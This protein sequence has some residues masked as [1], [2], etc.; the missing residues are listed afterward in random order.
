[1]INGTKLKNT[2]YS[3]V[4]AKTASSIFLT[5]TGGLFTNTLTTEISGPSRI[6]WSSI[7]TTI[8]FWLLLLVCILTYIFHKNMHSH[9]ATIK[10][11]QDT[12]FCLAYARSE[13]IPAQV[14]AIK[15]E[16]EAGNLGEYEDAMEKIKGSLK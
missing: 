14:S 5:I 7:P 1:M 10:D 11:F 3:S 9:E 8:S 2:F 12:E 15:K 4:A 13:L 16:I 6:Y